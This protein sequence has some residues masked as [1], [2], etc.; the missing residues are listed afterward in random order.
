MSEATTTLTR[1]AWGTGGY[2]DEDAI[3]ENQETPCFFVLY[4]MAGKPGDF[5]NVVPNLPTVEAAY[6]FCG[7]KFPD[8]EWLGGA[9]TAGAFGLLGE[10]SHLLRRGEVRARLSGHA[11]S[12]RFLVIRKTD[13]PLRFHL[14][15]LI[16]VVFGTF[17]LVAAL[18]MLSAVLASHGG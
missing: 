4:E 11:Q 14:Y 3:A 17:S 12:N 15:V 2:E 18:F 7:E 9:G 16:Y 13:S 8:I 5:S 10:V 1:A 6:D